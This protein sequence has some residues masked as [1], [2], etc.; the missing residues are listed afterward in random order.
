MGLENR[1]EDLAH[2]QHRE[3]IRLEDA[4]CDLFAVGSEKAARLCNAG[5]VDHQRH[6]RRQR[7]GGRHVVRP[8]DVE[9]QGLNPVLGDGRGVACAGV[10]LAGTAGE[11][12]ARE[13][14]ADAAIGPGDEG[15]SILNLHMNLQRV[16]PN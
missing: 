1:R 8:S 13:G 4:A 10:D 3:E 15:N 14:Q 11:Q 5:V 7:R 9:S 2:A 16:E 6:I 12:L